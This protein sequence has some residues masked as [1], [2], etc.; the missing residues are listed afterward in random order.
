[1]H[2][3]FNMTSFYSEKELT[4]LGL[5]SYGKNVF[6]S[7]YCR[8]YG[9]S[10]ISIGDNVRIDDYVVL[11]IGSSLTLGSYIHIAP[12]V[13]IIGSGDVTISD[14]CGLSGRV[15]LYSSTDDY[16]GYAMTNPMVPVEYTDVYSAPIILCKHVIVGCGSV[17]LPGVTLHEGA[18]I[19]A[20]TLVTKNCKANTIYG[21]NPCK[22]MADRAID[23]LKKLEKFE[24]TF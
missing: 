13:S 15:S 24:Q 5:K 20:M 2:N 17:I 1:M 14:Y 19:A 9:A 8:I 22:R 6:I 12:F 18:S 7:R 11:S 10:R 3:Y 4:T 23:Y 16:L 21:G